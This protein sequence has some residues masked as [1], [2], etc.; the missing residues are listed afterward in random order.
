M[1]N[2]SFEVPAGTTATVL[3]PSGSGKTTLLRLVMGLDRPDTGELRLG[4]QLLSSPDRHVPPQKRG[5]SMVFQ[6]FT[7][8]PNLDVEGNVAFGVKRARDAE[9]RVDALLELLEISQLKHRRIDNLSGGE[10]QRVALA[11]ALAVAPRVL[12]MD[13]PF[14]NIDA[15]LRQ[16]LF[17]R[18]HSYLR[19]NGITALV[20]THDHQEAF[21]FSDH[22]LVLKDGRLID[23][24]PPRR[25]YE[26]PANAWV[27]EFFGD[28]NLLTGA[29]LGVLAPGRPLQPAARYLVRPETIELTDPGSGAAAATVAKTVYYGAYQEVR[30]RLEGTGPEIRV[31]CTGP[32]TL[33]VGEQV[34]LMLRTDAAPHPINDEPAD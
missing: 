31:H 9:T 33:R 34:G 12:L 10:Q 22:I 15:M 21:Y 1:N 25:I 11:R 24:N 16:R 32:K 26:Q 7:L 28:T 27:A 19:A 29:E 17:E 30:L 8:F 5:M 6:E 14:S 3:G 2:L 20:A 18:L 4:D 13:E 23:H